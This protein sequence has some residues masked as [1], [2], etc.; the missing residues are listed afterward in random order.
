MQPW[1]NEGPHTIG[2]RIAAADDDDVFAFGRDV[3]L[4][5]MAA[6]E[7]ALGIGL[8]KFHREMNSFQAVPARRRVNRAAFVALATEHH[9]I[10]FF[11]KLFGG[12]IFPDFRV[13]YEV[14]AFPVP[15]DRTRR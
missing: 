1:R 10:K 3:G 12:I 6:I 4:I 8:Q 2:S 5:L 14:N 13:R 7:Q 11:E 9:R 15:A